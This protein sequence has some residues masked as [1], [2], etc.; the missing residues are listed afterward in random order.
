[1]ARTLPQTTK[2]PAH[3]IPRD[4]GLGWLEG[5]VQGCFMHSRR[6]RPALCLAFAA[7]IAWP[8]HSGPASACASHGRLCATHT[9]RGT[10]GGKRRG[11]GSAWRTACA[12]PRQHQV[13]WSTLQTPR[14][15]ALSW[16]FWEQV[17]FAA[18]ACSCA[19]Q[20][21]PYNTPACLK[22]SLC[23]PI[24]LAKV[25][26][27]TVTQAAGAPHSVRGSPATVPSCVQA[28]DCQF[29]SSVTDAVCGLLCGFAAVLLRSDPAI[30]SMDS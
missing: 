24:E 22:A 15:Q 20:H 10:N 16:M 21:T 27:H 4:L 12:A 13:P 18:P 2:P 30:A 6:C 9:C 5:H 11:A 26:T 28:P 23:P 25:D 3:Y 8:M 7:A 1:M 14:P 29:P 19:T 17:V